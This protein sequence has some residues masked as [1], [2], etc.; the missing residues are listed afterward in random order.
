MQINIKGA[1]AAVA[2]I[3]I[4]L[5]GI[6]WWHGVGDTIDGKTPR[7]LPS[8]F[9]VKERAFFKWGDTFDVASDGVTYGTVTQKLFNWT[10]TFQFD[11]NTGHESAI[12]HV[13]PFSW[14]VQIDIN[15]AEGHR[16]GSIKEEIFSSLFSAWTTYRILDASGAQIATSEKSQFFS[17]SFDI[18]A[19]DG[20]TVATIHRPA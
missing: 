10:K 7:Q 3:I 19:N 2:L 12:A 6:L 17:T 9:T 1:A 20:H 16:I 14:G 8:Q 15:D 4:A 13:Q 18:K 11:D 5:V